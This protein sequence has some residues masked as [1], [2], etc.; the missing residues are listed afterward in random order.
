MSKGKTL[1]RTIN[2]LLKMYKKQGIFA[3]RIHEHRI[4]S[5]AIIEKSPF[6]YIVFRNGEMYGFDAKET[7]D[8]A[9]NIKSMLKLH[10]IDAMNEI[11]IN[12]GKGFFLVYFKTQKVVSILP[13]EIVLE[14]IAENK[15]SIKPEEGIIIPGLDFLKHWK[16]K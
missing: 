9:I 5:G 4:A 14:K 16:S 12:G 3:L 13:V 6:D 15:K 11:R 7:N 1:E 10:Q 2:K 8:P